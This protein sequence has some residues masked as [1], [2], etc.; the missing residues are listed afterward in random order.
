MAPF[1]SVPAKVSLT[2][3]SVDLGTDV[4][5]LT[6]SARCT[7][8]FLYYSILGEAQ[9]LRQTVQLARDTPAVR[10]V[11]RWPEKVCDFGWGVTERGLGLLG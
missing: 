11:V 3:V 5:N 10:E 8:L 6:Q 4:S 1:P 7:G 2:P 9:A